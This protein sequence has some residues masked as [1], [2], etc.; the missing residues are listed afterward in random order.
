MTQP[1]VKFIYS[2]IDFLLLV[3]EIVRRTTHMP[4]DQYA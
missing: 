3:G 1:G 2:D 4:L